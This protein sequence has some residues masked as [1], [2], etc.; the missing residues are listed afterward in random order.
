MR[1]LPLLLLFS[2]CSFAPISLSVRDIT[3]PAQS[4]NGNVCYTKVTESAPANFRNAT[5]R[6]DALY[7]ADSLIGSPGPVTFRVYGRATPPEGTDAPDVFCTDAAETDAEN[8]VLS[9]A[10][11]LQPNEIKPT[12]IGGDTYGGELANLIRE[13]V[14]YLGVSL[15]GGSVLNSGETITLT[16]GEISVYF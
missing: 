3:L 1:F 8:I 2:A 6:A 9:D 14:Y 11:T 10:I 4:S 16:N 7:E 15:E 12:E 13:P 5:Y